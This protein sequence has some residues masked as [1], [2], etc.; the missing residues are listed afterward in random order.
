[1][2]EKPIFFDREVADAWKEAATDLDF[3][4]QTP[5]E[6]TTSEGE[7]HRFIGLVSQFG[8]AKGTVIGLV[9]QFEIRPEELERLGYYLSFLHPGS[10][11]HYSSEKFIATL[12]DWGWCGPTEER[13]AWYSGKPWC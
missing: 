13:P 7:P 2:N 10:Y 11:R 12:D 6:F 9:D 8:S 1:M 3:K 5:F 4:F